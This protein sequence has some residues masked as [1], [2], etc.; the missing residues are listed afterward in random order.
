MTETVVVLEVVGV[1][2]DL[3]VFE[4]EEVELMG[5]TEVLLVEPVVVFDE[6]PYATPAEYG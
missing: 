5:V 4:A 1:V 3:E 2:T 6:A